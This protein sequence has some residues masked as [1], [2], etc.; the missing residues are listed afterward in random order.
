MNRK[1]IN[2]DWNKLSNRVV[3]LELQYSF[4]GCNV[5]YFRDSTTFRKQ[6][7]PPPSASKTKPSKN[8]AQAGRKHS[9]AVVLL[10]LLSAPEDGGENC[11]RNVVVSKLHCVTTP[12]DGTRLYATW[13]RQSNTKANPWHFETCLLFVSEWNGSLRAWS[14]AI[15]YKRDSCNCA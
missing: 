8:T 4:L 3:I 7:S 5:I 15:L 6:I 14:E 9:N 1:S 13:E 11:L 12:E 2:R 10:D